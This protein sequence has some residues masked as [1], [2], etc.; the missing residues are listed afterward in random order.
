MV[1]PLTV[2]PSH[3]FP[4]ISNL[5]LNIGV[6]VRDREAATRFARE[7]VPPNVP[8]LVPLPGGDRFVPLEQALVAF[9]D[10]LFPGMAVGPRASSGSPGTPTWPSTTTLPTTSSCA[11]SRGKLHRRR[12]LPVVRLEVD[13]RFL[14]G[15][16]GAPSPTSWGWARMTSSV[17]APWVSNA[18]GPSTASIGPSSTTS[19]GR[20]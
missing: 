14:G 13:P 11:L 19:R 20:L 10:E 15:T 5:S 17:W 18:C 16:G 12:F 8:R 3:P 2:D 6:E 9:L 7:K 4:Y 1:T